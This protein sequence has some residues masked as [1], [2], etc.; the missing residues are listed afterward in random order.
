MKEEFEPKAARF[1]SNFALTGANNF[2]G[3]FALLS[4]ESLHGLKWIYL[5]QRLQSAVK[6]RIIFSRCT[7]TIGDIYALHSTTAL[8]F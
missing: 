1:W 2:L 5:L 3:P 7:R 6:S 8:R 4:L